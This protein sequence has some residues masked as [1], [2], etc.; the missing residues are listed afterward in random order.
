MVLFLGL[1]IA[2][3]EAQQTIEGY[4]YSDV[5]RNGRRDRQEAGIAGIPVSNGKDVV[6]T[7]RASVCSLFFH[8]TIRCLQ[9]RW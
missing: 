9:G 4:V 2:P 3:S 5:N 1:S 7:P 8:P 6:L